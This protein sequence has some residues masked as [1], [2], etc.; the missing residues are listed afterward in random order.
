MELEANIADLDFILMASDGIWEV[1][2]MQD[3]LDFVKEALNRNV[4]LG[5]I[6][7]ALMDRCIASDADESATGC[8]NMTVTL[9]S[10]KNAR[11]NSPDM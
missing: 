3:V 10:F 5:E 1:M 2:G 11:D 9:I 7:E 8:D 6:C 4:P